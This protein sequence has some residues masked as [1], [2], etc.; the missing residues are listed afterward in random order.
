MFGSLHFTEFRESSAVDE[1]GWW[2]IE[3]FPVTSYLRATWCFETSAV[4]H[5]DRC[6]LPVLHGFAP[7][8]C[9]H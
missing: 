9:Q 4:E 7:L 5:R 8:I 2:M 6:T 3:G 1:L